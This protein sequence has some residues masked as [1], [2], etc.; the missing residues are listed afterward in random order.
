MRK[1]IKRIVAVVLVFVMVFGIAPLNNLL[2]EWAQSSM[3]ALADGSG[4]GSNGKFLAPIEAPIAGSIP[5]SD[6]AGLEAINDNLSGNYHLTKDI[7]LS[8]AEWTPIGSRDAPFRGTFDGQGYI[9]KN[10]TI[11]A[12][13]AGY[14]GLFGVVASTRVSIEHL[15][16]ENVYISIIWQ[17]NTKSHVSVGAVA[18]GDASYSSG[19]RINNVFVTG[20]IYAESTDV[21]TV[22]G[23]AA[24]ARFV[25]NCYNLANVTG[26]V[27]SVGGQ[28][29]ACRAGGILAAL[30]DSQLGGGGIQ[31]SYNAG[32][33]VSEASIIAEG[34][35][36][37]SAYAAGIF[38]NP[39]GGSMTVQNCYNIGSI[40]ASASSLDLVAYNRYYNAHASARA[41]GIS[42]NAYMML[43][44]YNS[45]NIYST[46]Y[47]NDNNPETNR[48]GSAVSV[49][50]SNLS[51]A[52]YNISNCVSLMSEIISNG[53]ASSTSYLISQSVDS[54]VYGTHGMNYAIDNING[55]YVNDAS[56][57]FPEG[58][59]LEK[60][61]WEALDYDFDTVWKMPD[62]GGYPILQGQDEGSAHNVATYD[63]KTTRATI[64][65][66][67]AYENS[68][69]NKVD[70]DWGAALFKKPS[71]E[72]NPELA[73]VAAALSAAADTKNGGSSQ[74]A[75][76]YQ[77][78]EFSGVEYYNYTNSG[79]Y[80]T[81]GDH[82]F[83]IASRKMIIGGEEN[84]VIAVVCRGTKS[85]GEFLGYSDNE[86]SELFYDKYNAWKQSYN[87][88]NEVDK[89]FWQYI[90]DND[91]WDS[92]INVLITGHSLGGAAANLFA[93][94][95]KLS[96]QNVIPIDNVYAFTFG[97]LN[98]IS[99]Q[100]VTTG[101]KYINNIF[102][103]HDTFGPKGD[104]AISGGEIEGTIKFDKPSNGWKTI[105]Q[106]FGHILEFSN[107]DYKDEFNT[108]DRYA[109]HN[110]P[111]YVDAVHENLES[112]GANS[113]RIVALCPVD[114]EI[115]NSSNQLVARI[116]NNVVD[117]TV[118]TVPAFVED[119]HKYISLPLAGKYT[120]RLTAFDDGEMSYIV[121]TINSSNDEPAQIKYFEN[122]SLISDKLML[123][124]VG[125]N[126][127]TPEAKLYV[128]DSSGNKITDIATDGTER[129][130]GETPFTDVSSDDWFY[131]DVEYVYKNNLMNGT[132]T[133][134][135]SPDMNLTRGMLVTILG[136]QSDVDASKYQ[137]C[138]FTDVDNTQYYAHYVEW[139]RQ[140]GI[141]LGVGDGKFAPD[142]P[143]TRQDLAVIFM[144]FADY[145]KLT[146]PMIREY[147]IFKDY[148]NISA[149]AKEAVETLYLAEVINGKLDNLFDPHGNATRAEV[150]AMIHRFL[151]T[152]R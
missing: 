80:L 128:I 2:P 95:F 42:C 22:A 50:I 138:I 125:G 52:G 5:I 141:V 57:T 94:S 59:F 85:L 34:T 12:Y 108:T 150:A 75:S 40:Y 48:G 27:N 79:N 115:Y 71:S 107:R 31:N 113:T 21:V 14:Y 17:G 11:T 63:T 69:I 98:S 41:F 36:E 122:V 145:S 81:S 102:N 43:N 137:D 51:T 6:R 149:Y 61:T 64:S 84:T 26:V 78:L 100:N 30:S 131:P 130:I 56:S 152:A 143:I 67:S 73:L 112:T 13:D 66:E 37:C 106:K 24:S 119:E 1:S 147:S 38:G 8:G 28:S 10:M 74:L 3:I 124:E 32:T 105:S 121:E 9:I 82:C 54:P 15:G 114:V 35:P 44:C 62:D 7:D 72:Y 39:Y 53:S 23:I 136:R 18:G 87:F 25:R 140:T 89:Q 76:A 148:D 70:V 134:K 86:D 118:T 47:S 16:M 101:F 88:A 144:R 29:Q 91:L 151:E 55:D 77:K 99:S 93:A 90:S 116:S 139:A 132:D 60:T 4:Y 146:L 103:F 65:Y 129:P 68:G 33:I 104:G 19:V 142:A 45:G 46:A 126:I 49:G 135:F 97:A 92:K 111:A 133:D 96:K 117:A 20:N 127:N 83:S 123:S 58:K 120:V 110:M 109:N